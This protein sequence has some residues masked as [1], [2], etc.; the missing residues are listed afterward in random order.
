[1]HNLAIYPRHQFESLA[2]PKN[3]WTDQR[4]SQ[5]RELIEGFGE[6]ELATALIGHL[7]HAAREI[8]AYGVTKN[9]G[10]CFR[11]TDVTA[12]SRGNEGELALQST[13]KNK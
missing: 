2:F 6:E 9:V 5:R 7:M 13:A 3:F 10:F 12:F 11:G 1:L 4:R 8:I